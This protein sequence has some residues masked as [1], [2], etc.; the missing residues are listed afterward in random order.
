LYH[1][2]YLT[3]KFLIMIK[4]I[5]MALSLIVILFSACEKE[6][7][8]FQETSINNSTNTFHDFLEERLGRAPLK[9]NSCNLEGLLEV[10]QKQFAGFF[11][12]LA[13][14]NKKINFELLQNDASGETIVDVACEIN[15]ISIKNKS[16]N[17]SNIVLEAEYNEEYYI[18]YK[19][20]SFN[21]ATVLLNTEELIFKLVLSNRNTIKNGSNCVNTKSK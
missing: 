19:V 20:S 9:L 4:R 13:H 5:T 7:L 6:P 2:F 14:A 11:I 10:E 17:L 12:K 1:N 15:E 8:M 16:E 18:Y 3:E 21:K